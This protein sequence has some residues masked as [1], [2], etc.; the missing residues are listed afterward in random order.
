VTS[1]YL[2]LISG[3]KVK[4]VR[5]GDELAA[6]DFYGILTLEKDP[7]RRRILLQAFCNTWEDR[8]VE[9]PLKP[10]RSPLYNYLYG[11]LTG[12]P[13]APD[14][15]EQTLQD[16]PWDRVDWQ[17][18]NS[19]RND[20]TFKEGKGLRAHAEL[21]RAL[22]VSERHLQRWNGNPWSPDGGSDGK[23]YDDGAALL[24]GYWIGVHYGYLPAK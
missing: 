16:W 11:G 13:C 22:P 12:R 7:E 3:G 10:E 20:V 6:L 24:L 23:V 19:Q 5:D 2:P 14:E 4:L 8:S 1:L 21:T 9:Q 17:M 15:A 18:N